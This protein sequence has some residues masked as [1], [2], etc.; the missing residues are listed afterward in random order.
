MGEKET[1]EKIE[2]TFKSIEH[3]MSL[4]YMEMND[5][6]YKY[7][8]LEKESKETKEHLG[9]HVDFTR[10]IISIVFFGIILSSVIYWGLYAFFKIDR[11]RDYTFSD[12]ISRVPF[13]GLAI[14]GWVIIIAVLVIVIGYI[15]FWFYDNH[16]EKTTEDF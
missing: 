8:E 2:S 6:K 1:E 10:F 4:L 16:F 5:L 11:F 12:E 9:L 13:F 3:K 14:I 15:W 7:R